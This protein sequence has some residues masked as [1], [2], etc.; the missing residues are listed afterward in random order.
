MPSD[1]DGA[2]WS[3]GY[4]RSAGAR[5]LLFLALA[6]GLLVACGGS[7]D[8]PEAQPS[9]GGTGFVEGRFDELPVPPRAEAL[10]PRRETDGVLARS[11]SVRDTTPDEVLQFYETGL[12]DWTVTSA[13]RSIGDGAQGLWRRGGEQLRVTATPAPTADQDEGAG[14]D[15][16]EV[17]LSLQLSE[18]G[19]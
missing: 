1:D 19:T 2:R 6:V 8:E 10:G 15:P 14:T 5:R 12:P 13:P 17:Q 16:A 7:Q 11:W 3:A 18:P 9:P 4:N